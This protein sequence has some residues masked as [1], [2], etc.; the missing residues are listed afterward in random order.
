MDCCAVDTPR[1]LDSS[2]EAEEWCRRFFLCFS[3]LC[4]SFLRLCLCLL[5]FFWRLSTV[6]LQQDAQTD[7]KA[8]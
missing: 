1:T 3:F 2:S 6:G 7:G 4:F 8:H 5:F